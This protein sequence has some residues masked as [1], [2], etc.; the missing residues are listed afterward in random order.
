MNVILITVDALRADHLSY[1]GYSRET[2][3]Y[4]D[5]IAEEN[6]IFRRAFSN[7]P[8]TQFSFPSIMTSLYPLMLNGLGLP[9]NKGKTIAEVLKA[10]G[11]KTAAMHSNGYLSSSY[12][13][14][15]GFDLFWS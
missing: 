2:T 1:L 4:L 11:Y 14:D 15:R 5:S 8:T 7:G 10:H 9:K 13:Y 12:N 6:A 3:P